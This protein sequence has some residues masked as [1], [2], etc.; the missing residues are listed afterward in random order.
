MIALEWGGFDWSPLLPLSTMCS[1]SFFSEMP[2]SVTAAPEPVGAQ[3]QCEGVRVGGKGG[4]QGRGVR[5][6][7]DEDAQTRS[8]SSSKPCN[9]PACLYCNSK[10]QRPMETP[11][12]TVTKRESGL[13]A[14]E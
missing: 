11:V 2:L 1:F 10:T 5:I 8:S 12:P 7:S 14:R 3:L 4:G 6:E 9:T 13:T